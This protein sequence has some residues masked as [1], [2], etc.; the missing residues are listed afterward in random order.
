MHIYPLLPSQ[1][2]PEKS[3]MFSKSTYKMSWISQVSSL[4]SENT[5]SL[6]LFFPTVKLSHF[7]ACQVQVIVA[8]FFAVLQALNKYSLLKKKS[9]HL[10]LIVFMDRESGHKL[11]GPSASGSL[12]KL[13]WRWQPGWNLIWTIKWGRICSQ[14]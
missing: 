10:L 13:L 12:P 14:A 4:H 3:N 8:A 1:D 2:Q 7:P 11:T 9:T 6:S 5:W